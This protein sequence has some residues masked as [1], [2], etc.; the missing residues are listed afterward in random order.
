MCLDDGS[1]TAEGSVD[2]GAV[3]GFKGRATEGGVEDTGLEYT[4][5]S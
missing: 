2:M 3:V 1:T 4:G 5:G